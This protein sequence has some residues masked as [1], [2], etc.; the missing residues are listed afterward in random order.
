MSLARCPD[1]AALKRGNYIRIL[2]RWEARG[3]RVWADLARIAPRIAAG[4]CV[5]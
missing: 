5:F 2:E 4:P 3:R 1:P